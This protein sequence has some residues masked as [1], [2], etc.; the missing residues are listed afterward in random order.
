MLV[1]SSLNDFI[2][3]S[4]VNILASMHPGRTSNADLLRRLSPSEKLVSF[5]GP[6]SAVENL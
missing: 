3:M 6:P 5:R 2:D 1:P 4:T